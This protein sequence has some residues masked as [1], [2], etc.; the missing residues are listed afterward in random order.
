MDP[1]CDRAVQDRKTLLNIYRVYPSVKNYYNC[2]RSN[3]VT[4]RFLK[5]KARASWVNFCPQLNKD[6]PSTLLCNQAKRMRRSSTSCQKA[7]NTDWLEDFLGQGPP[8]VTYFSNESEGFHIYRQHFFAKPFI[9]GEF[10]TALKNLLTM[11]LDTMIFRYC[12][13]SNLPISGK[14]LLLYILDSFYI[15]GNLP[16]QLRKVIVIPLSK[17]G[18]DPN[19]SQSYRPISLMSCILK[20]LERMIKTRLELWLTSENLLPYRQFGFRKSFGTMDAIGTYVLH[21]QKCLTSNNYCT[22][23]FLDIQ[24]AYDS[25]DL[26]ILQ[27]K[28]IT[29][30]SVPRHIAK[31]ITSFYYS[32]EIYVRNDEDTSRIGP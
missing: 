32:R 28:L 2:L 18:K 30:V 15:Y 5:S 21:I 10:E 13:L 1:E 25:V 23:L 9:I 22:C 3:A 6:T 24:R 31:S 16:I 19:S 27:N 4:K 11:L 17:P 29:P 12:M 8:S 26:S 7:S 14:N 20:T